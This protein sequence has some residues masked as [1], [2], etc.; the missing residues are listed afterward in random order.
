MLVPLLL[1][2][3]LLL[4]STMPLVCRRWIVCLDKFY[5]GKEPLGLDD[6]KAVNAWLQRCLERPASQVGPGQQ[7]TAAC[8]S[9]VSSVC[10]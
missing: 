2:V 1:L 10:C 6:F 5:N 8:C 4:L 7:G 9:P 3:L